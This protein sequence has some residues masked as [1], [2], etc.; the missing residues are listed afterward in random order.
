MQKSL[1]LQ[2]RHEHWQ[3]D[4]FSIACEETNAEHEGQLKLKVFNV[5]V[6]ANYSNSIKIIYLSFLSYKNAIN[7]T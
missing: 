4:S 6:K 2:P 7:I 3:Y 5:L 1:Y